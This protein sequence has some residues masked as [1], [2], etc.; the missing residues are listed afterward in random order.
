MAQLVVSA[1]NSKLSAVQMVKLDD[2]RGKVLGSDK[3][4]I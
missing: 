2:F 4:K 1:L 3:T